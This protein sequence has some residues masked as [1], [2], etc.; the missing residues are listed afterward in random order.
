MYLKIL[1]T[2]LHGT[3][4]DLETISLDLTKYCFRKGAH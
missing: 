3:F 2:G 1:T 4:F